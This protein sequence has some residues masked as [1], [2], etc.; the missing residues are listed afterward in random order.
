M[1]NAREEIQ[2]YTSCSDIIMSTVLAMKLTVIYFMNVPIN[3][4]ALEV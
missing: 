4:E 2:F 3:G 1:F